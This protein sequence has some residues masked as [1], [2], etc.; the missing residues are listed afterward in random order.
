VTAV[1]LHRNVQEALHGGYLVRSQILII[2]AFRTFEADFAVYMANSEA[3]ER[4]NDRAQYKF[5]LGKM[6]QKKPKPRFG[7][8]RQ[9]WM[10]VM[11]GVFAVP[12]LW[13]WM[14][15]MKACAVM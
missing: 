3:Q 13:V 12:A 15:L 6:V 8:D 14:S 7:T 11:C 4:T 9:W 5:G 2:H 1:V 10:H